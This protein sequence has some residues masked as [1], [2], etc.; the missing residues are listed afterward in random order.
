VAVGSRGG[1]GGGVSRVEGR[2]RLGEAVLLDG[3]RGG[4]RVRYRG[5]RLGRRGGG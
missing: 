3:R 4:R 1:G 2:A 5:G